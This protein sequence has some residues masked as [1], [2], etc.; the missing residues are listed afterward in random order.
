MK[1]GKIF[2]NWKKFKF[3]N[4]F[5]IW[6]RVGNSEKIWKSEEKKIGNLGKNGNL[7]KIW[8]LGKGLE[9]WKKYW[10]FGKKLKFGKYLEI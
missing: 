7:V 3:V 9:I 8:K 6:K 10:K 5:E 2:R 4:K 1:F